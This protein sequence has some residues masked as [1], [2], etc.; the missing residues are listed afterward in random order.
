MIGVFG[1]TFD[2]IHYA[3]LRSA[4]EVQEIFGLTE[5]RF[6]PSAT[7]PHRNQPA[8]SAE[9]RREMVEL[10]IHN[11]PS[12]IC[13]PR[14]LERHGRS[15]MVDT[16]DSLRQDFPDQQLLLFIGM[17]AFNH[18]ATWHQW[19]RLFNFAHIVVMTRPSFN[20][21]PLDDFFITHHTEDPTEL[22]NT[23]AGKLYFQ[24]ITQ[25]DISA[26]AI[27]QMIA[28]QRSPRFLLPD[29]VLDYITQKQL[30]QIN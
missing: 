20:S 26:T 24:A 15:Y 14:E 6:I 4:L 23:L 11:Q 29:A 28:Q 17:D 9:R 19:Q 3:H 30:Y 13:D 21:Q 10:A 5:V 18:L 2:P 8:V 12:F 7:P 27:R 16:L 25:L 1:G 22:A